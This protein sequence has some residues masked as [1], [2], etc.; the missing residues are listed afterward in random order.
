MTAHYADGT[1]EEMGVIYVLRR[2]TR[3]SGTC[4]EDGLLEVPERSGSGSRLR[5]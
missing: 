3:R 2:P 4:S 5:L 1:S